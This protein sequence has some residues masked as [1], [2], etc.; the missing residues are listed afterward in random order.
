MTASGQS[1]RSMGTE[2]PANAV[3]LIGDY[4]TETD[5]HGFQ[6]YFRFAA[7]HDI[8]SHTKTATE[9][10]IFILIWS[11][12]ILIYWHLLWFGCES[13]KSPPPPPPPEL[14]PS[15]PPQAS[16]PEISIMD[17]WLLALK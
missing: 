8:H 16:V 3:F 9:V 6:L 13:Q 1:C 2:N 10:A 7:K 15:S 17:A 12:I 14:P 5:I 4:R 11:E